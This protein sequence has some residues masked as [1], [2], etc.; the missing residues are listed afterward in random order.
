MLKTVG[1]VDVLREA[2]TPF[3][4]LISWAFVYGSIARGEEIS[5]SDIDLMV[6]GDIGLAVLATPLQQVEKRLMRPV[7]P[8]VYTQAEVAN[9][10]AA[11]HPFL[12]E[13][14]NR[15]K[16]SIL[17]RLDE[18]ESSFRLTPRSAPLNEPFRD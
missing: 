4:S 18:L 14:F 7:N 13:V 10:L 12:R 3:S 15:E 6:I 9:K 5:S 11:G 1:L 8:T 17:G 2:L 16:L